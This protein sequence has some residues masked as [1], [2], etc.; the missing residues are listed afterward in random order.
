MRQPTKNYKTVLGFV[1][2]NSCRYWL[3]MRS[4]KCL[5]VLRSSVPQPYLHPRILLSRKL[6]PREFVTHSCSSFSLRR[7]SMLPT[8]LR[9]AGKPKRCRSI[10]DNGLPRHSWGSWGDLFQEICRCSDS[11][12]DDD[13]VAAPKSLYNCLA[14]GRNPSRNK[15]HSN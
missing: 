10:S 13:I 2:L 1:V 5:I 7:Q 3:L 15:H 8:A 9:G 11:R 14:N 12:R 4:K 6:N